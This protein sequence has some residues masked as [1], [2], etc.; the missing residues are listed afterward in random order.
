MIFAQEVIH[1]S[2]QLETV[3]YMCCHSVPAKR[4][5]LDTKEAWSSVGL[6]AQTLAHAETKMTARQQALLFS[7]A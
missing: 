5:R 7:P 2:D 6:R 3:Q 4:A 1:L